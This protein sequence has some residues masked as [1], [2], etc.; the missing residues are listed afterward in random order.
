MSLRRITI[1]FLLSVS[2]LAAADYL[3]AQQP[4]PSAPQ[5]PHPPHTSQPASA[6]QTG[7]TIHGS[8]K[9]GAIPLPGVSI[10]ATN[11]LTG[12]KYSTATDARGDYSMTIPSNGRYVLRTD[13]A[14]FASTT[15]EALLNVTSHDQ[16]V[17]FSL[18]LTSRAAQEEQQTHCH[19]PP[20]LRTRHP[21][22]RSGRRD[23]RTDR[24]RRRLNGLGRSPP[25]A[26]LKP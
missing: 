2:Q 13:L 17:D 16:K 6:P 26:R 7:G 20:V 18:T 22:S 21:K 5:S 1:S 24:S 14:A 8:V 4:A 3:R 15:Q 23:Q 25:L 10:T 19:H 9:A 11:T 12:R